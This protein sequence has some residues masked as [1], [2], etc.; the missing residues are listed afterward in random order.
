MRRAYRSLLLVPRIKFWTAHKNFPKTL[1]PRCEGT[2]GAGE[3]YLMHS[4][5]GKIHARCLRVGT[6]R[7]FLGRAVCRQ[8]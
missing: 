1:C 8:K 4:T 5:D 7:E 2:I 6:S 3:I